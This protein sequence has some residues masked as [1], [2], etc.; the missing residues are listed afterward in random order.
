MIIDSMIL[1]L[2]IIND[3]IN[4]FKKKIVSNPKLETELFGNS[5]GSSDFGTSG[6][7]SFHSMPFPMRSPPSLS[8]SS[9]AAFGPL[10]TNRYG[11]LESSSG[12]KNK[13]PTH[14]FMTLYM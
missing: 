11:V 4:N 13:M 7:G 6:S 2:L 10:K 1:L 14:S 3:L 8:A 12:G 9:G 5:Q